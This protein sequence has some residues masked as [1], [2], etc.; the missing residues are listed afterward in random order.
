MGN[1][2]IIFLIR[3][4]T[5]WLN[6]SIIF[7][8]SSAE[9][10]WKCNQSNLNTIGCSPSSSSII[11]CSSLIFLDQ[12]NWFQYND[13]KYFVYIFL[14]F[15]YF[16]VLLVNSICTYDYRYKINGGSQTAVSKQSMTFNDNYKI[17][18]NRYGI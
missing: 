10:A 4:W 3:N 1:H 11:L 16:F 9:D 14:Y 15:L 6:W 8:I 2:L 17:T 13:L 5:S 18:V 12:Y 7:I